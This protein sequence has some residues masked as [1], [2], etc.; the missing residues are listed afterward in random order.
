MARAIVKPITA[1][2]GRD[3]QQLMTAVNGALDELTALY[4]KLDADAGIT[5]TNYAAT[6]E[7]ASKVGG[8][9]ITS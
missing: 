6:L 8:Q 2:W 1:N 4:A 3:V 9:G 7:S 5:D